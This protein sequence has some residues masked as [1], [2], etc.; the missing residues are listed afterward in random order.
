M[1]INRIPYFNAAGEPY[2]VGFQ[3]GEHF[4]HNIHNIF[5]DLWEYQVHQKRYPQK[6]S[7]IQQM[8]NL[9]QKLCPKIVEE[10]QGLADG[11]GSEFMDLFVHNCMHMPYWSNC[12]TSVLKQENAIYIAHNEDAHP[13]L[14]KYAYYVVIQP[15]NLDSIPFFSHCYPGIV[16]GMSFGFNL[17]GLVQTCNSLPDPTR[18]IGIPRIFVGR[19]TYEKA[20][21]ISDVLNIIDKLKP[22]S[23]GASYTI[24]SLSEMNVINIETTGIDHCILSFKKRFFRAN[25]YLSEVYRHHPAASLHTLARQERGNSMINSI[26]TADQLLKMMLDKSIRLTMSSTHNECQTNSTL[27]FEIT[28][29]DVVLKRYLGKNQKEFDLINMR[30]LDSKQD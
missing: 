29:N 2:E 12:S 22:R 21:T 20:K 3:I 15:K 18:S 1:T 28:D 24:A 26:R 11:S 5:E 4:K 19:S 7:F 17:S 25:H 23:G 10:I 16:A 6:K 30:Y 13:V 27:L 14:E 9:S 8:L